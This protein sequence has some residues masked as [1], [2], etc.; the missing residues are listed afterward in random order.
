M[1]KLIKTLMVQEKVKS[2]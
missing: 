1:G 2:K